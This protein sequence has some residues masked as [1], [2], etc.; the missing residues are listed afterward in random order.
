MTI[1]IRLLGTFE[2]RRDGEAVPAVAWNRRQA[3]SL[4]KL[5]ALTPGR[6]LHREQVIDALWPD[7]AVDE[8]APRLHKA[9]YFVRKA[10]GDDAVVLRGES[11]ALFP[12]QSVAVDVALF[13]AAA[14]EALRTGDEDLLRAACD[15]GRGDLLPEDPYE[16]WANGP[17]QRLSQLRTDL[18]RR[19]GRWDDLVQ[20]DGTDEEAH[21]ELMR[22]LSARGD[23]HGALRQFERLD[24]AL[25][26]ELGVAPSKEAVAL[27]D[28]LLDA[29]AAEPAPAIEDELIGRDD[30]RALISSLLGAVADSKGGHTLLL[31]GVAGIGKSA[32]LAWARDT[33]ESRGWRTGHGVAAAIEGAW[34]YA[35]ILE[36]VADLGRRHPALLD[37]LDDNYRAEIERAL[38]GADLHWSGEGGHQRL[39]VAVAE[40]LRLA[41]AHHGAML[42][43]D[44]LHEADEASLRL[45]HYLARC[46]TT[47]RIALLIGYRPMPVTSRVRTVPCQP[48]DPGW[49]R[50][51]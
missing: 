39:F 1:E 37:G 20:L 10:A 24:R 11:V 15:R 22:A 23:R 42:V 50:R 7:L 3:A 2:V 13:E 36:A 21:L 26:G 35:P 16:E 12:D 32:V 49:R 8:A 33:A 19:L 6:R 51:P 9:A 18:L 30:E 41:A 43:L 5:L 45:T 25:A 46:A 17:R 27:R 38:A 48:D 29:G 34:A 28:A 31:A 4:V 44:D 47:E 40:L 14:D